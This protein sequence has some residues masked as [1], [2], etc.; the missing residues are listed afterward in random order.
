MDDACKRELSRLPEGKYFTIVQ[1]DGGTL[2]DDFLKSKGCLTFVSDCVIPDNIPIP[3]LCDP[4]PVYR[5]PSPQFLCTFIGAT[6]THP[7]RVKLRDLYGKRPG[8]F[9]GRGDTTLFRNFMRESVFCLAPR[10]SG[11]TSFRMYEAMQMG[12]IPVYISDIHRC[13]FEDKVNWDDI[14]IRLKHEDAHR[15]EDILRAVPKVKIEEMQ[16]AMKKVCDKYFNMKGTCDE[17][18]NI[19]RTK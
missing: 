2:I 4:H 9:F 7:I 6:D 15:V 12:C 19:L 14:S 13:P 16:V 11:I 1:Y 5:N 18:L 10:G 3:L 8:F 17:V